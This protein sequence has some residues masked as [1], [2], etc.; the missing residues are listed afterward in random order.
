MILLCAATAVMAAAE[1]PIVIPT[2]APAWREEFASMPKGSE[3]RGRP[4]TRN[5]EFG[6]VESPAADDG[7]ALSMTADRASASILIPLDG[8]DVRATPILRWRWR[9]IRLP[10][11]ADGRETAK[12]DQA[13]GLYVG[14][15][16]FFRK[17]S[18]AYRW[19]TDTP[20]G[21]TGRA[22]YAGGIVRVH[23]LALRNKDSGSEF[24][25]EERDLA[26]DWAALVGGELPASVAL[27]VSCNS[28]YT[29][30]RA[31]AELDWIELRA[32]PAGPA[33]P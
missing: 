25:V 4:G 17:T 15:D 11:G 16:G 14:T 27:S 31:E 19:E 13:I 10:D 3:I 29:G 12:D 21:A 26:E 32:R 28:Q 18:L 1:L 22:A 6:S 30:T 9:V 23:W 24:I 20:I 7:R 33:A 8:V 5:A 2:N